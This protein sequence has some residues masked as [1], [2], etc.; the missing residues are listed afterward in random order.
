MTAH[1]EK[2]IINDFDKERAKKDFVYFATHFLID[3][4]TGKRF[5]W[6]PAQIEQ[7]QKLAE[8]KGKTFVFVR[9]RKE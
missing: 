7:L 4:T 3:A 1:I 5:Q 9:H 8:F 2:V 6:T